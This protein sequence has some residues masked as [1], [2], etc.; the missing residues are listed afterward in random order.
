MNAAQGNER[1]VSSEI[2][3]LPPPLFPEV[4]EVAQIV[5]PLNLQD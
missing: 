3:F 4:A 5:D 2:I 1:R